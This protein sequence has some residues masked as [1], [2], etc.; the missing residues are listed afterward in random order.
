MALSIEVGLSCRK[1]LACHRLGGRSVIALRLPLRTFL[2]QGKALRLH[3]DS[4]GVQPGETVIQ[5]LLHVGPP[6]LP[7]CLL[8]FQRLMLGIQLGLAGRKLLGFR[9]P[10][11]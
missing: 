2:L 11:G 6:G 3:V 8:L 10:D 9:R 1:L 5:L 4:Q 7:G